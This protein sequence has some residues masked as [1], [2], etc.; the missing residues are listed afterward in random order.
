MILLIFLA[1]Q[2]LSEALVPRRGLEPPRLAALVPETSASTSSATWASKAACK[3]RRMACQCADGACWARSGPTGAADCCSALSSSPRPQA[4][5]FLVIPR[6]PRGRI[7]KDEGSCRRRKFEKEEV[8][9]SAGA[10]SPGL[11]SGLH[12]GGRRCIRLPGG[13]RPERAASGLGSWGDPKPG[14]WCWPPYT[15]AAGSAMGREA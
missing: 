9:A 5:A 8:A 4:P 2:R 3:W 13:D 1:G 14:P 7:S 12:F 10:V 6:A 15:A 11:G